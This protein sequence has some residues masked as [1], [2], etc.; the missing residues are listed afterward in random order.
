MINESIDRKANNKLRWLLIGISGVLAVVG[1][2]LWF[3]SISVF[4]PPPRHLRERWEAGHF[5]LPDD[6]RQRLR[7]ISV[8]FDPSNDKYADRAIEQTALV[9]SYVMKRDEPVKRREQLAVFQ[10]D[11]SRKVA[12]TS[13]AFRH[14][15]QAYANQDHPVFITSDSILNAFHRILE[16]SILK[17]E[18]RQVEQLERL[19]PMLDER[20]AVTRRSADSEV[21]RS[22]RRRAQ[23][24]IGVARQ[25]IDP[26]YEPNSEIRRIVQEETARVESGTGQSMSDWLGEPRPS[27]L[28]ID[29]SRFTPEGLHT[30]SDKLRRHYRSVRWLQTIP[31]DVGDD[32]HLLSLSLIG[33]AA[34]DTSWASFAEAYRDFFG[35]ADDWSLQTLNSLHPDSNDLPDSIDTLRTKLMQQS[36]TAEDEQF[37]TNYGEKLA[38]LLNYELHS[39]SDPLDD[40]MR[41]VSVLT[42]AN[43]NHVHIAVA[44]P[45]AI[46]VLYPDHGQ[47]LLCRGA[48]F[49]YF[50]F[51][52]DSVVDD[53]AWKTR[54]DSVTSPHRPRWLEPLFT[55]E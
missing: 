49:P 17:L 9:S 13:E 23:T 7:G 29:Y 52:D 47:G 28:G 45:Q 6:E 32:E 46:Y 27:F 43:G 21:A 54:V 48:V 16:D 24:V 26:S 14:F 20:L 12:V 41:C 31:F 30:R 37:I 5:D 3:G 38:A 19:L 2:L 18:F 1:L 35:G 50:E 53:Q 36:L 44:R 39:A 55:D 22:A 34:K 15:Y 40:A 25:L 51:S 42:Q 4:G 33:E 10:A 11:P 8:E